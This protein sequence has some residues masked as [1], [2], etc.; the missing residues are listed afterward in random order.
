MIYVAAECVM[1][2][3]HVGWWGRAP[4]FTSSVLQLIEDALNGVS[5]A[6]W[7]S[8]LQMQKVT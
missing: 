4:A 6:A 2:N 3:A 5:V 1:P 8:A 7:N